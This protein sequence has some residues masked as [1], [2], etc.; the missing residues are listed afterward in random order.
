MYDMYLFNLEVNRALLMLHDLSFICWKVFCCAIQTKL[1]Q[2]VFRQQWLWCTN[3]QALLFDNRALD[4]NCFL[5]NISCMFILLFVA[6]SSVWTFASAGC[7]LLTACV[8]VCCRCHVVM[9]P[10]KVR[11]YCTCHMPVGTHQVSCFDSLS[12]SY[13]LSTYFIHF[14]A[15]LCFYCWLF[16]EKF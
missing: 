6:I 12:L 14:I 10:L 9:P 3:V 16:C 13:C 5:P 11:H 4:F 7:L 1:S 8:A 2:W 15:L